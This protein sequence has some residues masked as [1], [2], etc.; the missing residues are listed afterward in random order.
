VHTAR[1]EVAQGMPV[2]G[3]PLIVQGVVQKR[4]CGCCCP[5]RMALQWWCLVLFILG[6][7]S[8]Y[9][10]M[11]SPAASQRATFTDY[12]VP[13]VT[14]YCAL[15]SACGLLCNGCDGG[16]CDFDAI[17]DKAKTAGFLNFAIWAISL[18]TY[19]LGFYA[20]MQSS[21]R[22]WLLCKNPLGCSCAPGPDNLPSYPVGGAAKPLLMAFCGLMAALPILAVIPAVLNVS[23]SD[24]KY[25][26]LTYLMA[27]E[28]EVC[29]QQ[30][31]EDNGRFVTIASI[32]PFVG[33]LFAAAINWSLCGLGIAIVKE[34]STA[35]KSGPAV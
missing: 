29:A 34:I 27:T 35:N 13:T 11:D 1:M 4:Y 6:V 7:L 30:F 31:I 25:L 12:G 22:L 18:F 3:A 28:N 23:N 16:A 19:G 21:T 33:I 8:I 32:V 2:V 17:A 10:Y 9:Q 26:W 20:A 5:Y 24:R 14:A 15:P